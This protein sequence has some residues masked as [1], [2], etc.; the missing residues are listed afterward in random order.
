MM[1]RTSLHGTVTLRVCISKKGKVLSAAVIDGHPMA[2]QAVLDSVQ[3]WTF[4]PYRI[5]GRTKLVTADL[6]VDYDFRLP[7][8]ISNDQH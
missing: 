4:E 1:E 3:K 6:K 7:P 5:D 2:F 8:H